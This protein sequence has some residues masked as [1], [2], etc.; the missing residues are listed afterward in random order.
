M[1][2]VPS[3]APCR[4]NLA[5]QG[6]GSHGAF[7]W[8]VLDALLEDGRIDIEGISG[9]S[10]GAMNAVA[11]A[12]GFAGAEGKSKVQQHDAAREALASFWNGI[13]NMGALSS[14]MSKMQ[15]APFDILFG[16]MTMG[17]S[18]G[19]SRLWTDA[20]TRYWANTLSPY[21]SN[22]F[23]I[24]PLRKFLESQV[25]FE[26]LAA[27]RD[28]GTPKVFV[29]ATRV[30]SGKAEV[31]SGKRLTAS[32]VMA[33]AC[34]PM[35]FQAVEIE[36]SHFWDGGYS[37]NP[38]IHPLIYH[39]TSRDIVLVQINPIKR[40]S[41]PTNANEIMDR[42]NE[43]TF[44][45]GLIAEM[46]AIDFVKR[47]LAE[48]KLDPGHYKNVL[49]HRVDGG[50]ALEQFTA[51]TK[52][53]TEASLIDGLR[54]LGIRCC[55]EWLD[56]HYPALG[57][58]DSVNIARDYLDDLRMP[59]TNAQPAPP[60]S[61]QAA[62]AGEPGKPATL[63]P[64][65]APAAPMGAVKVSAAVQA[66]APA[67]VSAPAARKTVRHKIRSVLDNYL[68]KLKKRKG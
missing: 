10:A 12:H 65:P 6:G 50:E 40:E 46:R 4:V 44:N 64:A 34:L 47:L 15:R 22:P 18:A 68:G 27:A 41:L 66:P 38:A 28:P 55:K 62:K 60:E 30:T 42:I 49:M 36:G 3:I 29:V 21:Q 26:R 13:V 48:G 7:T 11:L 8:G 20:M 31:F 2:N 67:P 35:V 58:K 16:H 14:S 5:L 53:S 24:N 51:S 63:P 1:N 43:I 9:T 37:G 32:A 61:P 17:T 19:P 39:C 52:S 54:D 45:A 33:S 23:D 57:V 56:K 25:D 59:V